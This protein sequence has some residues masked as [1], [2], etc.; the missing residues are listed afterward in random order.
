MSLSRRRRKETHG[1]PSCF[2]FLASL[3]ILPLSW[4]TS[5]TTFAFQ[6]RPNS[7]PRITSPL[8]LREQET[9][10]YEDTDV[11]S[12]GLVSWLT[13]VAVGAAASTTADDDSAETGITQEAPP[14]K[15]VQELQERISKDYTDRNY[16]WTGNLD[17]ACFDDDCVFQDPTLKFESTATYTQ[18]V[19]SLVPIVD[20]WCANTK[21]ILLSS[22]LNEAEG[23]VQTRWN[24]VGD[25]K[26]FWKP[27]IN[28]I[29]RTKFW[30]KKKQ[31]DNVSSSSPK[32]YFYDE[33]WE[34]PAFQALLQLIT[35]AGT[36]PN[37]Q[38][39]PVKDFS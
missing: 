16:L 2:F 36:I 32:V 28:V 8:F 22:D 38:E 35:P 15:T 1:V 3:T 4:T 25:I 6:L 37:R 10:A 11:A 34:I 18:N 26:L 17:L 12:K 5:C 30:Y 33:E 14:P 29:G 13:D 9:N 20:Q 21:S 39:S 31:Q 7:F 27:Q 19:Q 24:M 23:Y